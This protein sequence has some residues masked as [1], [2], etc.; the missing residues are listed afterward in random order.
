MSGDAGKSR[1]LHVQPN[2][3]KGAKAGNEIKERIRT[4]MAARPARIATLVSP[5]CAGAEADEVGAI[6]AVLGWMVHNT[7]SEKSQGHYEREKIQINEGAMPQH[8]RT[9][10]YPDTMER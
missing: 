5:Q 2:S 7:Q 1:G 9:D 6:S 3:R 4:S 8:I 10:N